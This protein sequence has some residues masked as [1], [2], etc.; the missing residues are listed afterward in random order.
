MSHC[1]LP[2]PDAAETRV[3]SAADNEHA[4][5]VLAVHTRKMDRIA[6]QRHI[7]VGKAVAAQDLA[8]RRLTAEAATANQR[9]AHS[10]AEVVAAECASTRW[11]V[12]EDT[13]LNAACG[14]SLTLLAA[15]EDA[16]AAWQSLVEGRRL[17]ALFGMAPESRIDR[18]KTAVA[19]VAAGEVEA[20]PS[21][22]AWLEVVVALEAAGDVEP[23]VDYRRAPV[24]GE[25]S[26]LAVRT[27][28]EAEEAVRSRRDLALGKRM[29]RADPVGVTRRLRVN[30][31]VTPSSHW[32]STIYSALDSSATDA[33]DGHCTCSR[34]SCSAPAADL[35]RHS[36]QTR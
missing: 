32:I 19:S 35:D 27:K 7:A 34:E 12:E 24:Q 33:A 2:A 16:A 22:S 30:I 23:A 5:A 8:F 29:F 1:A 13:Q 17:V 11:S 15:A 9:N 36:H 21:D 25:V 4:E 18:W 3:H 31:S 20:G 10:A 6:L 26:A 28:T 14:R